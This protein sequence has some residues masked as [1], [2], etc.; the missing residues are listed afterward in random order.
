MSAPVTVT[1]HLTFKLFHVTIA[2]ANIGSLKY[3][4]FL[5]H[6]L[7]KFEQNGMEEI[8]AKKVVN[9]INHFWQIVGSTLKEVFVSKTFK[10]CQT[11]N[12]KISISHYSKI[13]GCLTRLT[14]LNVAVNMADPTSLMARDRTLNICHLHTQNKKDCSCQ[15]KKTASLALDRS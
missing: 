12:Q 10:W 9:H 7:V 2:V 3:Y 8:F 14:R 4:L 5:Y 1:V 6:E 13:Y 15:S 11:V